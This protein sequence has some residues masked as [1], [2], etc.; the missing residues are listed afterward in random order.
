MRFDHLVAIDR[1][2]RAVDGNYYNTRKRNIKHLVD[3][4]DDLFLATQKI[5]GISST[6]EEKML[7]ILVHH[8]VW[9]GVSGNVGMEVDRLPF[10]TTH[11]QVI[12]RLVDV[13]RCR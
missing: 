11:A 9:S 6:G 5:P 8:R 3:P 7:G 1:S 12:Q 4:I 13:T 10:H 2:G